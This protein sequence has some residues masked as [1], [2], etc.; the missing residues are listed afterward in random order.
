MKVLI[1]GSGG[2]EHALAWA[3][4]KSERVTEVV[5][6]PGNGGMAAIARLTPV[7][8]SDLDG[9]IRVA[10]AEQADL[11]IVGPE[12]P[13]SLGLVDALQL[14]GL[15][16]FG[17]TKA[18]AMLESSKSFAKRFLQRHQIPTANYAVC[19]S[20]AEVEKAIE[21]FHAPIVVKADG[22]AAGK[23]VVICQSRR[24]ALEAAS[25][26]FS[27]KLLG[28]QEQQLVIEE[29]LIGDEVSFLCLT[30]GS[31]VAPLVPAQ[32]H[33]R[34]GEG[35]TGPNTGGM[36]VYSTDSILEPE[37]Q[38]WILHHIARPSV[39]GMA[40]EGTPFAGVLYIGLMMTA[41]GRRC[42]SSMRGLAIPRRRRSCCGWKTT[43]STRL[44]LAWT[45]SLGRLNF[46]GSPGQALA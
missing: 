4:A 34:V 24:A 16:V 35:D 14:R 7:S 41:R 28:S 37:M 46:D 43:W 25:G 39:A 31:H 19:N 17:P 18:A 13:L 40:Q 11:T 26:L 30:D 29:F 5:C 15:K 3:I 1:F 12:L 45:A 42:W 27:G 44:R 2:R 8:L 32:D 9:M 21:F 10:V 20:L 33:K 38:E 23:G 6:A 36:G 22:L